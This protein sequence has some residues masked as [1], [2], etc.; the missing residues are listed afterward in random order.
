[1][2][3]HATRTQTSKRERTVAVDLRVLAE[4]RLHVPESIH[5]VDALW[6]SLAVDEARERRLELFAARSVGHS[7][8]AGAVPIDLARLG[9]ECRRLRRRLAFTAAGGLGFAVGRLVSRTR[10]GFCRC[11]GRRSHG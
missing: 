8:E 4:A 7:A 5:A 1:M 9:V 2:G 6:L 11:F 10:D 3:Q